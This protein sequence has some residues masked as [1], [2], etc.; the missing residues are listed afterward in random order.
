[1]KWFKTFY[2]VLGKNPAQRFRHFMIL[3]IVIFL[4]IFITLNVGYSKKKGIY[5][6]PFSNSVNINKK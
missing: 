3:I 5:L 6:T 4:S 2:N 1:M